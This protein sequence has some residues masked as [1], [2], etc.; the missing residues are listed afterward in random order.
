M[1]NNALLG[2][3]VLL[4]PILFPVNLNHL[5]F[6]EADMVEWLRCSTRI[7]KILCSNLS[8]IIHGMT[9]ASH[10]RQCCLE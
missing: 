4:K 1:F 10:S 6:I 3:L 8:V 9:L 5:K 7:H 2:S